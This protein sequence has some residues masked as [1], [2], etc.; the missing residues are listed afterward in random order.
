MG[1]FCQLLLVGSHI[2]T[3]ESTR[4]FILSEVGDKEAP[5]FMGGSMR[6]SNLAEARPFPI[7]PSVS[8]RKLFL[9]KTVCFSGPLEA[10][11]ATDQLPPRRG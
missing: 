2:A 6:Q 9:A 5:L 7:R 10:A 4:E 11:Q 1:P 8:G 3:G